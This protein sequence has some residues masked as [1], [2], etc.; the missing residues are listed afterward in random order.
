MFQENSQNEKQICLIIKHYSDGELT[1]KLKKIPIGS[2][3]EISNYCGSFNF[4]VLSNCC[5]LYLICAG[6]GLT[7]MIRI[8]T[9]S[10]NM[11]N[12]EMIKLIFFN[13]TEKDIIYKNELEK[14]SQDFTK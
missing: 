6:S 3:L 5:S 2:K 12:I 14:L 7:P 1:S 8:L 11:I 9:K 13:K 4:D 10:L